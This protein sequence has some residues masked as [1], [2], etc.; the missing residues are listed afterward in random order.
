MRDK[1][2]TYVYDRNGNLISKSSSTGTTRYGYDFEN[3]LVSVTNPDNTRVEFKYD[4]FG[5]R[6]EKAVIASG[7]EAISSGSAEVTRYFY[8]GEDI[9]VETDGNGNVGNR[10]T[11]GPGIDEPLALTTDK[12]VYFY[13]ADGLGSIVA[14]TDKNQTVVQDYQYGFFGDLKDLK[15]RIKQPYTYTAR[16]YDR[17]T[18][19]Y[20]YRARYYDAEA[21]R[22]IT[23]DPIGFRGGMNLY[24]YVGGNPV[25]YTDPWGLKVC[26]GEDCIWDT[27]WDPSADPITPVSESLGQPIAE[28]SAMWYAEQYQKTGNATYWVGGV[29]AS[30][31]T[32]ETYFATAGTLCGAYGLRNAGR[33]WYLADGTPAYTLI[34][35][36]NLFRLEKHML[37]IYD[38]AGKATRAIKWHIDAL[39][40]YIKHWLLKK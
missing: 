18:G 31:W 38:K 2:A 20:F 27:N 1:D 34:D 16:E 37:T 32:P 33:I 14:L 30:A 26:Y 40:G 11:H 8:D 3:R 29:I 21:G 19:L 36:G 39:G 28:D 24:A 23:K 10:Y 7:G 9:L 22:F 4:V 15:N 13:H 17:E 6:I 5:R 35:Y 25:N 12:G